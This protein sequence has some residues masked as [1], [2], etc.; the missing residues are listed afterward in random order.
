[1]AR[2]VDS[3]ETAARSNGRRRA[4]VT[5][6]SLLLG[7]AGVQRLRP[8][9]GVVAAGATVDEHV[10]LPLPPP[11]QLLV[12]AHEP[13]MGAEQDVAGQSGDDGHAPAEALHDGGTARVTGVAEARGGDGSDAVRVHDAEASV[14]L[15]GAPGPGRAARSVAGG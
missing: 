10:R 11:G 3:S 4:G 14:A 13:G 1:M 7:H 9:L 15:A 8:R 6:R 12:D 5:P 2:R